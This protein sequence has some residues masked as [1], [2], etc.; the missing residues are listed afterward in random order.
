[1]ADMGV[2]EAALLSAAIGG[3]SAASRGQDP[4]QA[5]LISGALGGIGGAAFG[6]MGAGAGEA[7]GAVGAG[8]AAALGGA[9]A[10]AGIS[11]FDAAQSFGATPY[12]S[13]AGDVGFQGIASLPTAATTS[14]PGAAAMAANYAPS[15]SG[16]TALPTA[17]APAIT[18]TAVSAAPTIAPPPG[19]F[20]ALQ[21]N[22]GPAAESMS[23]QQVASSGA[24]KPGFLDSPL[25]WWKGLSGKEQLLY[26][27]GAGLAGLMA[28]DNKKYGTPTEEKYSGPLSKFRYDPSSYTP[29][30]YKTYADGGPIDGMN[31]NYPQAGLSQ[32]QYANA[33]QT[34]VPREMLASGADTGVNPMTGQMKFGSGGIADLGGYSDGGRLLRGPGDGVSDSI[35]AMIGNKQ[36]A[37]LADGEFVVPARIVSELGNG[38]TDAGAKQ[39]YAMMDRVQ[40]GRRKTVGKGKVAANTNAAKYLPA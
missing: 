11:A 30:S 25:Q 33:W 6:G 7:A 2:G 35:P 32:S 36:P 10:P 14:M 27:G 38:S 22:L 18:P 31:A 5:A 21:S 4:L 40:K 34:P 17:A 26:G 16:I 12:L 20:E 23:A 9:G 19:S 37:R 1:M 24:A 8:E 13:G 28:M 15:A 39:L 3:M 29:Y